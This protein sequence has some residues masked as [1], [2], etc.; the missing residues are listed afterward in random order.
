MN[1]QW[2]TNEPDSTSGSFFIPIIL[3]RYNVV[4]NYDIWRIYGVYMSYICRVYVV[5]G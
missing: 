4:Y 1:W 5:C 3:R 2:N